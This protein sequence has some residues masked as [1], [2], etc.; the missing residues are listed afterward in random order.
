MFGVIAALISG[1]LMSI[2]GVFNTNVTKQTSLWVSAAFVQ[3]TALLVCLLVWFVCDRTSFQSIG[4]VTDKYMLLGG[5]IGAFITATV[6]WS[7]KGLGPA[8]A[9]MLIVLAQ[10]TVAWLIELAGIFGMERQPFSM[11]KLIGLLIA[12]AGVITFEL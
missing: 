10:L 7:M 5:T 3:F 4:S 1:A 11:R 9:A 8:K 6:I 12:A 2:Q